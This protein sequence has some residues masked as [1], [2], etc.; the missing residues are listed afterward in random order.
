MEIKEKLQA[1]GLT[2]NEIDVYLFL[3][4]QGLSTP[5][6]IAR[7]AG[8]QRTHCYNVLRAL[9]TQGLISAQAVKQK[10]LAYVARDPR[11]LSEIIH[12][13]QELIDEILP[14]L[15]GLYTVNKNKPRIQFFD[16]RE[17][18]KAIYHLT[19]QAKEIFGIG[20]TSRMQEVY[21]DFF[22]SYQRKLKE[23][24]IVF[25]DILSHSS[26]RTS[27]GE[28]KAILK[29]LYEY[30]TLRPDE[31]EASMDILMWNGHLAL[32]SHDQPI[33]GTVITNPAAYKMFLLM[34]Q[35]LWKR[36]E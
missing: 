11:A 25:H 19:L 14:D 16:G 10:R 33:F 15:S 34:F 22:L 3:L 4:Q 30:K 13:K 6:A 28:I 7:G 26:H 36:I 35:A 9:Q 29:G 12:R 31:G 2:R 17:E 23:R 1:I 21:G 8:L 18:V 20:S 5:P 24:N 27:V 32:I